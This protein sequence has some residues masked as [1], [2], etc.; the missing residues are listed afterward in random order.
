MKLEFFKQ[1]L[2]NP[3]YIKCHENPFTGSHVFQTDGQTHTTKLTLTIL[4]LADAPKTEKI[5]IFKDL[6]FHQIV[7]PLIR[8]VDR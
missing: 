1:D 8:G 7:L 2:K 5:Y 3:P 4:N 6:F